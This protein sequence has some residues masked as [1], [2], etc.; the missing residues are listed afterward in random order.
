MMQHRVGI[1]FNGNKVYDRRVM[2]GIAAYR[3]QFKKQWQLVIEEDYRCRLD[4]EFI[5]QCDAFIADYDDPEVE[6]VLSDYSKPVIAVGGSYQNTNEY[7]C[8][9]YVAT[10]NQG[11]ALLALEHFQSL[12][13]QHFAFYSMPEGAGN[14]WAKEREKAFARQVKEAGSACY[15][16]GGFNSDTSS[17]NFNRL[18]DWLAVLP[19]PVAI[20]SA[21]DARAIHLIDACKHMNISVP[22]QV[23]ILGV[24]DDDLANSLCSP[25]LSSVR[26]DCH[27]MGYRAAEI[28]GKKLAGEN[29][30]AVTLITPEKLE[31]RDSTRN[32]GYQ[33]YYVRMAIG[34]I[35]SH[36][37]EGI[38]TADIVR[39][40]GISR[41]NLENRFQKETGVSLHKYIAN[42]QLNKAKELLKQSDKSIASIAELCGYPSVQYLYSLF[43]KEV[44]I[45][46]GVY[47]E[48][49]IEEA[50]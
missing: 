20:L 1:L 21:T 42:S 25:T 12:G 2:G 18:C 47:R 39:K 7:P 26:Q 38:R 36:L 35:R 45:T 30:E 44:G 34:L 23:S 17:N 16:F 24:D 40:A 9:T 3:N 50:V 13:F 31:Q 10:D 28:L 41:S 37:H 14:R 8:C 29:V 15:R 4:G 46:P 33:D 22:E 43:R 6:R 48:Q 5:R 11:I 49:G 27:Q 19:K 32:S